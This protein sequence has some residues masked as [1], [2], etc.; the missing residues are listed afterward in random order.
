MT[1]YRQ[2]AISIIFLFVVGFIATIATSISNL[3]SFLE[4]QLETHA[5]DTATSL[6]LSLSPHMRD[7]DLPTINLMIDA[8]FD[9]GYF[10]SIRL[11]DLDENTLVERTRASNTEPVPDWFTRLVSFRTPRAEAIVMSG[12]KQAGSVSVISHPEFAYQELWS[13]TRDIFLLFLAVAGIILFVSL[14]TLRFLLR[15]LHEV[16]KQAEAI[17][18]RSWILQSKLPRTRELRRVVVAMNKLTSRVREIFSDQAEA[19]EK[20]RRQVYL[21]TVTGL[22]NRQSFDRQ[23]Q[24]LIEAGEDTAYGALFLVKV[25]ALGYINE[26]A[27]YPEGDRL[28]QVTAHLIKEKFTGDSSGFVARLSGGEFGLLVEGIEAKDADNLAV[29]LCEEFKRLQAEF[30]PGPVNFA[31]IGITLLQHG[32]QLAELLTESDHA[33]RTAT[34]NAAID[35]HRYQSHLQGEAGAFGKEYLRLRA[36][37]AIENSNIRLFTQAVYSCNNNESPIQKEILLR[38]PDGHGKYTNTGIYHPMIDSMDCASSLDRLVIGKLLS[39]IA[40]ENSQMPYAVNLSTASVRDPEFREWLVKTLEASGQSANRIQLELMENTVAG[41]IEQARDLINRL[42]NAGFRSGIDHFGKD[43]HPFGYLSTLKTSYI[44]IDGYYTRGISQNR[45]NQFFI[46]SLKDTVH[47]LG[48]EVVA[49]SVETSEEYET[50]QAFRL[51]GY[52]GYIFGRPEP[53]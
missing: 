19:T 8:I 24:A 33:L 11:A 38:L 25:D 1:L 23:C 37:E 44:K 28:L 39:H 43:F 27:G 30:A 41:N 18:E 46:K 34:S 49:Q 42:A 51:D 10:Q 20:L 17:C 45:D 52:Q 31:H 40:D 29:D 3:S 9:R 50:L 16:E 12:W 7:R 47:T 2:L 6:G 22:A 5:Q 35:W 13:N 48:I 32:R 36:L 4:T 15:P 26:S 14:L 53:L 21:D